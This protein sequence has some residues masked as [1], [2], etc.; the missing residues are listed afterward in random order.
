MGF[1][2][3]PAGEEALARSVLSIADRLRSMDLNRLSRRIDG[4][5]SIADRVYIACQKLAPQVPR[6]SDP[7]SGDQWSIIASEYLAKGNDLDLL[8]T[9]VSELK[10]V[11]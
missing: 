2:A 8:H 10:A 1:D 5:L 11:L 7:A 3:L 6:L 4:G 9:Q